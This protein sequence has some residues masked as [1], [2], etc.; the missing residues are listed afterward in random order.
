MTAIRDFLEAV[1]IDM[2][3]AQRS[4]GITASGR[5]ASSLTIV[6]SRTRGARLEGIGYWSFLFKDQGR[7]PGKFPPI[8][9]IIKW[10]RV[11]RLQFR[12]AKGQFMSYIRTAFLV[13][14]KIA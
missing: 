9:E 12:N 4:K 8:D 13:S 14:R 6:G 2:I 11:R 5:S 7:K 10:V 1:K 3:N